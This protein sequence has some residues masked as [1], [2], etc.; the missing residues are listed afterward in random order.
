MADVFAQNNDW[1][2]D[3]WFQ[4]DSRENDLN[5]KDHKENK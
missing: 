4:R 2:C 1:N 5:Q 3:D